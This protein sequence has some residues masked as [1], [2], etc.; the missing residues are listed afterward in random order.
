[1]RKTAVLR[2]E[3]IIGS[4]TR[5]DVHRVR[6]ESK[7]LSICPYK[8]QQ[9]YITCVSEVQVCCTTAVAHFEATRITPI[10]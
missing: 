9:G 5:R 7:V 4:E 1:M 8:R 6:E 3:Q 10:V 2:T